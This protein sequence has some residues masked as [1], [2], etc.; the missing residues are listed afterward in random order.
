MPYCP[1]LVTDHK[2]T[3]SELEYN[4]EVDAPIPVS[5]RNRGIDTGSALMET[6][7]AFHPKGDAW[8][9][10]HWLGADAANVPALASSS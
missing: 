6:L 4:A 3:F 1:A 5:G 7:K 10:A 2:Y 9:P 8:S